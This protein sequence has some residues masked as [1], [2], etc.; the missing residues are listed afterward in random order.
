MTGHAFNLNGTALIARGAGTLWLAAERALIVSDLH[1][2][3][4]ARLARRG[5]LLPPYDTAETLA[6][7]DAEI[8]ATA[9][10][11]V[12]CLGDSFDD[13]AAADLPEPEALWLTRLMAGRRWVWIA[14]NHDPGPVALGGSHL[15]ELRLGPLTLRHIAQP[16][17]SGEVSGH[18]HPKARIG[19]GPARPAF[20]IDAAR[21]ILPAF[22]AYTGGL[23]S[24]DPALA[25][26]MRPEAL[27]V[28]TGPRALALPMPR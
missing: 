24:S 18:Y 3:K 15:A 4:A 17:T 7:L 20:L 21:V 25:R 2:G 8:A 28:L 1:F 27:A 10:A 26:L 13:L 11:Q 22:G 16:G 19:R 12:I 5:T 14:G 23:L 9:P 6:R